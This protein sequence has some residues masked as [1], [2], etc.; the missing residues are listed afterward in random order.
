MNERFSIYC[1]VLFLLVSPAAGQETVFF[2]GFEFVQNDPL[3]GLLEAVD[4][5]GATGQVGLWS[6]DDFPEA[7]ASGYFA[8]G[9]AG[10]DSAGLVDHPEGGQ[11]LFIDRPLDDAVHFMDLSKPV[12]N[13]GASFSV[14]TGFG[15]DGAGDY[16][17]FGL[18]AEGNKSFHIR[19]GGSSALQRVGYVS[20]GDVM[21]DL[22][23]PQGV[24]AMGDVPVSGLPPFSAAPNLSH[25]SVSLLDDG[26][27]I[28]YQN[29][30][31]S[32]QYSTSLL[33]YD[34][35]ASTLSR[36][37]MSYRGDESSTV[38][39]SSFY[40]DDVRVTS[41]DP[42]I[43]PTGGFGAYVNASQHIVLEG[44]G[45]EVV[46]L[47]FMSRQG[48]LV[49]PTDPAPFD[50]VITGTPNHVAL[51]FL[52]DALTV[53]GQIV[54]GVRYS[55]NDPETELEA[56][57]GD[58]AAD[59]FRFVVANPDPVAAFIN[60]S[61]NIVLEGRNQLLRG[62]DFI[63]EEGLLV[64]APADNS[65]PFGFLLTNTPERVTYGSLGQTVL[66]DG[67]LILEA[68]Y[69]GNDPKSELFAEWGDETGVV[70]PFVVRLGDF[71]PFDCNG[72]GVVD[73][74][75][76]K[77]I[78]ATGSL[79][80]LLEELN[81][82]KGDL[83]ADGMVGFSDFL[84]ISGNFLDESGDYLQGDLDC[85]G[86]VGFGDF[87]VLASNYGLSREAAT[88]PEPGAWALL[89]MLPVVGLVRGR[90]RREPPCDFRQF[91]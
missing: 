77:C 52:G 55:G 81:L 5:N 67:Q 82:L 80:Q 43:V 53:D 35:S 3:Y 8:N 25:V 61:G 12:P 42:V 45:Q 70:R 90:R 44:D 24:D 19:I 6:G 58:P 86:V 9:V 23:T 54:T 88:V 91:H 56:T 41:G 34:G 16:D 73:E 84:I 72:D 76:L 60:S 78:C 1:L 74:N 83:N 65:A 36:V 22:P 40:L 7:D 31:S 51:G 32:S 68:G 63:S 62:L 13:R 27:T 75:D 2:S 33:P 20:S 85:S 57:W 49:P 79:D 28:Q 69:R 66:L 29:A 17:F 37:G 64:P 26:Y 11:L 15:H 38:A 50:F 48:L 14:Q 4:L 21:F 10:G 18:D 30:D 71:S 39:Q 87:I 59:L 89:V 46:G 47:E